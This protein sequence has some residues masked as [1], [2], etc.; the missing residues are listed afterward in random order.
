MGQPCIEMQHTAAMRCKAEVTRPACLIVIARR[1]LVNLSTSVIRAIV[2]LGRKSAADLHAKR[3]RRHRRL[4]L[5]Q[6]RRVTMLSATPMPQARREAQGLAGH[7][8]AE[9]H[10]HSVTRGQK[11]GHRRLLL[12]TTNA[13]MATVAQTARVA[14]VRVHRRHIL[15]L[16]CRRVGFR[17]AFRCPVE[18]T[19][20]HGGWGVLARW[21]P[22]SLGCGRP[23]VKA[24]VIV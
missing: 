21:M 18:S 15:E 11:C 14:L 17:Y 4:M 13:I 5:M 3:Q 1:C 16:R 10:F 6:G 7:Y 12:T 20:T 23:A 19:L 8:W 24:M 22:W 2:H 9:N